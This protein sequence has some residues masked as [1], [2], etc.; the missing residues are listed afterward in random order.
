MC[1][2]GDPDVGCGM[3]ISNMAA[4]GE[5]RGLAVQQIQGKMALGPSVDDSPEHRQGKA[6]S[7][8]E[9]Q[10]GLVYVNT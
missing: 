4:V 8:Q 10:G 6:H 1:Q 2:L 7:M 3:H 5:G 9:K